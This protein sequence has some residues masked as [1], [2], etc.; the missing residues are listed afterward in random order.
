M[1]D[2]LGILTPLGRAARLLGV[3]AGCPRNL[4]GML[5]GLLRGD[6][7]GVP[8]PQPHAHVDEE[9]DHEEQGAGDD[10]CGDDDGDDNVV[11]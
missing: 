10:G 7:G 11:R 4:S 3:A 8:G 1:H 9:G 5:R 6:G 2:K